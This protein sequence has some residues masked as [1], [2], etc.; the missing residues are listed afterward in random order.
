MSVKYD[1]KEFLIEELNKVQQI[2]SKIPFKIEDLV[3]M[4]GNEVKGLYSKT[5]NIVSSSREKIKRFAVQNKLLSE[6]EI[7][8]LEAIYELKIN[9]AE[10]YEVIKALKDKLKL[11]EEIIKDTLFCLSEKGFLMLKLAVE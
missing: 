4:N 5:K 1:L 8:V 2:V 7:A 10:I 9:E 11:S 3:E 6:N